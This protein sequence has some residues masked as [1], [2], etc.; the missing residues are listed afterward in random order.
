MKIW[1]GLVETFK[2]YRV[3]DKKEKKLNFL[4]QI[5][6]LRGG[7]VTF[8]LCCPFSDSD[9][10]FQSKPCVKIWFGLVEIGCI[11]IPVGGGGSEAPY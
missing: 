5:S 6:P 11:K 10:L 4:G 7:G 1:F 3:T 2:S 8:D 9:E